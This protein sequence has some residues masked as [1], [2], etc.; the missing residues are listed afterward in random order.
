MRMRNLAVSFLFLVP[1]ACVAPQA[2]VSM[3]ATTVASFP[4]Q[5]LP[6]N[7]RPDLGHQ[8]IAADGSIRW[9][10]QD[11]FAAPPTLVVLPPGMI[12]DRFGSDYGRFFSP[13]GASYGA[14]PTLQL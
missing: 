7:V 2:V 1:S 9:P 3:Q 5:S 8:W 6:A 14:R 13:K 10:A 4:A 12:I 11:G